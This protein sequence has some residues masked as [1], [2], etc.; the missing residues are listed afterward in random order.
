MC[1]FIKAVGVIARYEVREMRDSDIRLVLD[2]VLKEKYNSEP[3]TV[4][5]HEVGLCAGKRR[6]DIA[7]INSEIV[8]YEIKSDE[9]TLLRLKGQAEAYGYVLDKAIIVTT[10]RHLYSAIDK[11]PDWWGVI[12]A[13]N[14]NRDIYLENFRK[15]VNNE[16]YDA[17]SLAQLLWREEALEELRLRNKAQGLSKKARYYVWAALASAVPLDELRS[18]V[19]TRLK[20]RPVWPGGQLHELYDVT[21]QTITN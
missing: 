5:R 11:L 10:E 17:F 19:R 20:V 16:Q 13:H 2:K 6:I 15:P 9:D 18:I 3:D 14:Q 1:S 7:T 21:L 8:G 12:V 4:I